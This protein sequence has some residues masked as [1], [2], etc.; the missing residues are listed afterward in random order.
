MKYRQQAIFIVLILT[1][2]SLL[3]SR[4]ALSVCVMLFIA[5]TCFHSD[6]RR[7][8]KTW[9]QT[10]FLLGISALFFIPMVSGW[11]S[12]NLAEW[13]ADLRLKLPLLFFPIAFAGNWQLTPKQWKWLAVVF[14]AVVFGGAG[15]SLLQ[16]LS[17]TAVHNAAVLRSTLFPTPLDDDHVRFSWLVSVAVLTLFLLWESVAGLARIALVFLALFFIAYLHVLAARTGL[18]VLYLV[19]AAIIIRTITRR[20]LQASLAVGLVALLLPAIAWYTLPTFQNRIKYMRY[21]FSYLQ[22]G[23]YLPGSNDGN[24]IFSLK[25]GYSIIAAQPFGVGSGDFKAAVDQ[26]YE[27]TMPRILPPD[28]VFPSSE[29]LVYGGTAGWLGMT[30][31]AIIMWLPFRLRLP[32]RFYWMILNMAMLILL[33][34][35]IGLEVQ[36]GVFLY[37]FLLL[38][39]WKWLPVYLRSTTP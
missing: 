3:L 37:S 28:K 27:R 19:L 17:N 35:D 2:I 25:A 33:L 13:S 31:F 39:W 8:L 7:Q 32:H 23:S 15:W 12:A 18:L 5:L 34:F 11:W 21:D 29:V 20:S 1:L 26:W 9:V 6:W 10:P 16:Y 24:R 30:A 36:Y 38:W 22:N 14:L 4:V